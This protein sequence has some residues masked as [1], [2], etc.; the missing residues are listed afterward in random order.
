MVHYSNYLLDVETI[1]G[2]CGQILGRW[3]FC[4]SP[5]HAKSV[6]EGYYRSFE[7]VRQKL[8]VTKIYKGHHPIN[9]STRL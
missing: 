1:T 2:C 6:F 8:Q 3:D 4:P 5:Q 9:G 7:T